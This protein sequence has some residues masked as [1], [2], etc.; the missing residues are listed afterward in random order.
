MKF[1]TQIADLHKGIQELENDRITVGVGTCGISAGASNT[2]KKLQDANLG[3]FIDPVGCVGM[4]YAEPVVTVKQNGLL[5]IYGR[6]TE[7]KADKLINSI[8]AGQ[9]CQELFMGHSLNDIDYFKKQK[10][11]LMQNSGIISPLNLNQYIASSGYSG[12]MNALRM[13]PQQVIDEVTASGLRGRGGA[14][15]STG[16]KWS[17]IAKKQGR[18]FLVCNGDEGDPGAFMN[19]VTMESDPFRL[20]EGMTIAAYAIGSHEGILYTRAEYPLAIETMEKA[21]KI[22]KEHTLLGKNIL[23]IP[24]FDFDI[25]IVKGSGAFVCGEETALMNSVMSN[26]GNP[27]F[28]PPYPADK[29]IDGYPTNINNV[30]TLSLVSNILS[31]T[32]KE[33]AIIGSEKSK[34]TALLCLTGK[35][36]RTGVIEIPLG[37]PLRE[38]I[39][40]IGG[41]V[42]DGKFKAVQ[43]GGPA[44]GCISD[45]EIDTLVDYES[46]NAVGAMIG[47]GGIVAINDKT[48]IVDFA[49]F[50]M[51]FTKSE[52]CGKCTP[53]REGTTR[54][55]EILERITK[56]MGTKKDMELL[57][58]LSSY[59]KENSLCGLGQAAPNPILSTINKFPEEYLAHIEKK[60]CPTKA[61]KNLL[62]YTILD[63][64][65]GCGNCVKHCPVHAITGRLKEKHV[66]DQNL[67]VRCGAC[68][69][70]CA[71]EAI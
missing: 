29:G 38:V 46:F 7:D 41:G 44:G 42:V 55:Y 59:V 36:K 19:R 60:E 66:I 5:S 69:E 17:L 47:S 22:A 33:F 61:C 15:F 58:L 18:K 32:A 49:K 71:F 31:M 63:S 27:T 21:I 62:H 52:S 1:I 28:K 10:R 24:E 65:V 34:G 20:I 23:D 45:K 4:C 56:G 25:K 26:R 40:D 11:L 53:C 57:K 2:L 8:R 64:C 37:T 70:A 43:A 51:T 6:V 39:F 3:I 68:F 35:I 13:T 30:S 67:C 50:F 14:G 54:L 9:V 48:C 12:L 16:T